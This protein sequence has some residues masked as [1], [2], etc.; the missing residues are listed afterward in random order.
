[1]PRP[2][3]RADTFWRAVVH[4]VAPSERLLLED[5]PPPTCYYSA[6]CEGLEKEQ[7]RPLRLASGR[8]KQAGPAE[9]AAPALT[10][11]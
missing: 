3:T 1:M 5:Q 10:A 7:R 11:A 9:A 8:G 2:P 6:P 4:G